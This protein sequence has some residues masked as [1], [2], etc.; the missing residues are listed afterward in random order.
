MELD[1]FLKDLLNELEG[2]YNP[3]KNSEIQVGYCKT[4]S[5]LTIYISENKGTGHG[6]GP[7]TFNKN[8]I[9]SYI[10]QQAENCTDANLRKELNNYD[11][12]IVKGP[13]NV[14]GK[15]H[16][17][18]NIIRKMLEDMSLRSDYSIFTRL[19]LKGKKI[20]CKK[21]KSFI[22]TLNSNSENFLKIIVLDPI[23]IY[24]EK[25]EPIDWR[26]PMDYF[27]GEYKIPIEI[28][29]LKNIS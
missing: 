10:N 7:C 24:K 13:Q 19:F 28:D 14:D 27:E 15:L 8:A 22:E 20:P 21:C 5:K 23:V 1:K 25:Q 12:K 11:L 4:G 18:M 6:Y 26:N 3:L 9:E 16:A 2:K 29:V 17:E